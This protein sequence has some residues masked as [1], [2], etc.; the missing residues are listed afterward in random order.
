MSD[1]VKPSV[2]PSGVKSTELWSLLAIIASNV[3]MVLIVTGRLSLEK[4]N[5]LAEAITQIVQAIGLI[6]NLYAWKWYASYRNDLKQAYLNTTKPTP[7]PTK[8]PETP[9]PQA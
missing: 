9:Q 5:V 4:G 2:P 1:S 8:P 7:E 6:V 3:I